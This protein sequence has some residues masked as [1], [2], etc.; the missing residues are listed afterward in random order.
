[1]S[2]FSKIF[3]SRT[4]NST[5]NHYTDPKLQS[6]YPS[7]KET[8][9][10]PNSQSN[11]TN[12][13][14]PISVN[15]LPPSLAVSNV[16]I[17]EVIDVIPPDIP[18][19]DQDLPQKE[20]P[21]SEVIDYLAADTHVF[22][23][24]SKYKPKRNEI[25]QRGVDPILIPSLLEL[26][27]PY[28]NAIADVLRSGQYEVANQYYHYYMALNPIDLETKIEYVWFLIQHMN[29]VNQAWS[30]FHTEI[31]VKYPM[32]PFVLRHAY[33]IYYN[34]QAYPQAYDTIDLLINVDLINQSDWLLQKKQLWAEL[35]ENQDIQANDP[36]FYQ[37]LQ[38]DHFGFDQT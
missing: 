27:V 34:L 11:T 21:I 29:Q 36:A 20:K 2:F 10:L 5:S 7:S 4:K 15:H 33:S 8:P 1:M 16:P 26:L 37:K 17:T 13:D 38:Q 25:S 32:E 28:K 19:F 18:D 12:S 30:F 23:D 3:G 22:K 31:L 24:I 14:I 9:Q 6:A 35:I